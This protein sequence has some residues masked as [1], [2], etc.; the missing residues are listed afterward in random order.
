LSCDWQKTRREFARLARRKNLRRNDWTKKM[1]CDWAPT[2][3]ENPRTGMPFTDAGAW[4]LIAELLDGNHE[5]TEVTL[6]NPPGCLAY[7]TRV[8]LQAN[9]AEIY[10]KVQHLAGN[11]WGRSFHNDLLAKRE[12]GD[13]E[14]EAI[15]ER[16]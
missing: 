7:E 16:E 13:D 10:I 6:R 5:F 9:Y 15:F 4:E 3:V 11:I 1:P 2:Q 14:R 8:C 12:G